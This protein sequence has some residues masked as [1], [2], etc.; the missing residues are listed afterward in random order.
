MEKDQIFHGDCSQMSELPEEAVDFILS[1]PP[2][3]DYIDYDKYA[4]GARKNY[5]WNGNNSYDEFLQ[6]LK[7]WYAECFRVL[8]RGRYCVVN[9]GVVRKEGKSYPLPF[10]VVPILETL[11]FEFCFEIVWHK[12]AGGRPHAGT[13]IQSPFPGRYIP[14]NHTEYLLVFRKMSTEPFVREDER[15]YQTDEKIAID[16]LFTLEIA[17]NVWHVLPACSLPGGVHPCAFPPE[18]PHR[19]IPL[20]TRAG[21]V[22]LDPFMGSGTTARAAKM[23]GRHYIGYELQKEFVEYAR[24]HADVP[25]RLR[26]STVCRYESLGVDEIPSAAQRK[27]IVSASRR[28]DMVACQPEKMAAALNGELKQFNFLKPERIHTLIVST[29]DFRNLLDSR[30]LRDACTRC[31]QV[32]VNLTVTG[33]G[34]TRLEPNVPSLDVLLPRLPELVAFVK[35]PLRINWCFDPIIRWENCSN[36]NPEV[37]SLLATKFASAGITRVIAMFYRS[38]E[39][40]HI[41]PDVFTEAEKKSF[42]DK[43]TQICAKNG[44]DLSVCWRPGLHRI[45]CIDHDWLASLHPEKERDVLRHYKRVNCG[46]SPCRDGAFDIGWYRPKCGLGCLYCYAGGALRE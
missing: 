3:W 39:K 42:T 45:R 22:V 13:F 17:N 11:G 31:D 4:K 10:H 14:N 9:V 7:R 8:R 23:L 25:L 27:Y 40:S 35:N 41:K 26:R 18:L 36:M 29:K 12:I 2:Y 37:F 19:L 20:F 15:P 30:R 16:K 1:G 5:I 46:G 38:Y 34:G 21:E 32:C 43:M 28:T 6:Q 33:L 24:A 44:M